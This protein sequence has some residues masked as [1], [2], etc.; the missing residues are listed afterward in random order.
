[1]MSLRSPDLQSFL[2]SAEAAIRH[3]SGADERLDVTAERIFTALQVPSTQAGSQGTARLPVCRHLPT[4]LDRARRQP[5]PVSALA[6][7]FAVIEPQLNWQVRTGAEMRS[8]QFLNGHANALIAGPEGIEKRH[9][10]RIGVSLM[11]P[12]TR[13]PDHHHPPA[14]IYVVLSDG[15][16]RQESNPW[17]EP[18]IGGLVYNPPNIAHAMRSNERPLLALWFLW[19]KLAGH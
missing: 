2:T 16:W 13:Y 4:A 17:H 15:Q 12:H 19:S 5:G 1:M 7:A 14:E 18:G 8:E 9:D 10:V 3:S 6:D 11:A